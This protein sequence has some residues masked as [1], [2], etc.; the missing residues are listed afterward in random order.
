MIDYSH[1]LDRTTPWYEWLSY[2]E[3]CNS[4]KVRPSLTG[5]LRYNAYYRSVN[6]KNV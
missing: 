5:F 4:L 6:I 2:L 3:C 1:V